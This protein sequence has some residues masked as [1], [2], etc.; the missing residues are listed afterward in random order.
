MNIVLNKML[1]ILIWFR[2]KTEKNAVATLS[3]PDNPQTFNVFSSASS[4]VSVSVTSHDGSLYL[5][6]HKLNGPMKKPLMPKSTLTIAESNKDSLNVPILTSF[7]HDQSDGSV[8][9][10]YGNWL[11]LKFELFTL[12]NLEGDV[13]IKRDFTAKKKKSEK[14]SKDATKVEVVEVPNDV[15]HLQP[16]TETGSKP[17]DGKGKKRKKD[18]QTEEKVEDAELPMEQRLSNLTI[19]APASGSIPDGSNLAHLLSQVKT[20][21]DE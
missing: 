12:K 14:K 3:V 17:S 20:P 11:R 7:L 1:K 6:Q 5:F 4:I 19:D 2:S 10:G 8:I 9:I 13:T 15:K 18:G 21:A 16:G